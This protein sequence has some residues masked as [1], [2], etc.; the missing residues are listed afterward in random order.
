MAM[1]AARLRWEATVKRTPL[2]ARG[3]RPASIVCATV[4]L[5]LLTSC[6][7]LPR[8]QPGSESAGTA[9]TATASAAASSASD[10]GTS[11]SMDPGNGQPTIIVP[12]PVDPGGGNAANPL[13]WVPPGPA[14]PTDP[15]PDGWYGN[16]EQKTCEN[17]AGSDPL[18][19]AARDL[20]T[21]V[22]TGDPAAWDLLEV[23]YAALPAPQGCIETAA[24]RVL[25][26]LLGYHRANPGAAVTTVPG[27]G[28]ACP[29]EIHGV[30]DAANDSSNLQPHVSVD[31]GTELRLAGRLL[32]VS[33]VLLNGQRVEVTRQAENNFTFTAPQV[34]TPG[35]VTVQAIGPDGSPVPGT[36][37]FTYDPSEQPAPPEGPDTTT[38]AEQPPSSSASTEAGSP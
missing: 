12:G 22:T 8:E 9:E 24:H 36:A 26:A 27:A 28:T 30:I 3:R 14:D 1:A 18:V 15:P 37:T 7:G 4:G 35:P 11:A 20:C 25:T 33:H 38:Q 6:S 19:S 5:L 10:D 32:E 29:L 17:M 16:L 13:A 23:D 31:G 21:A 2:W 34:A